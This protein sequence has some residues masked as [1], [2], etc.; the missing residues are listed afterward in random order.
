MN[1]IEFYS[2][3]G[4][5]GYM[6]NFAA[7]PTKIEGKFY[8]TVEHYFQSQK[9]V[10][11]KYEKKVK[12][13][14]GPMEAASLGRNRS[15]PLRRDWESVKNAIMEKAIVAKFSQYSDLKQKL[16]NTGNSVLVE[17]SPTDYYWGCGK[18]KSGKN[19]LGHILM[20]V[21]EQLR[22]VQKY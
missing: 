2:T 15:Y 22:N 5:H 11:T 21:R 9:F 1:K 4:E 6:S 12:E 20:K 13:A 3:Y 8:K 14:S 18:N 16:L 19:M 17:N 10:N 7:Y